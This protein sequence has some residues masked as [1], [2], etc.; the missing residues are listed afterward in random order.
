MKVNREIDYSGTS[1]V[2]PISCIIHSRHPLAFCTIKQV[3]SSDPALRNFVKPYSNIPEQLNKNARSILIIDVC[4]VEH[5]P[6]LLQ[7]WQSKGGYTISLLSIDAQAKGEDLKM[8]Y[9]G[10]DGVVAFTDELVTDLPKAVRTVADGKLW[11]RRETLD[12]YV[13]ET[14]ALL[15]RLTSHAEP[16]TNREQQVMKLLRDGFSNRQIANATGISERTAKFHVSNILRKYQIEDRRKLHASSKSEIVVRS[17]AT[18]EQRRDG[19]QASLRRYPGPASTRTDLAPA[20]GESITSA[21]SS[22][23]A[24]LDR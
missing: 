20:D 7:R 9:L 13:K 19:P 10:V 1:T 5:W 17:N 4:S 21:K 6:E 14:N 16:L 22:Q 24:A 12:R 18:T 15:G 11:V 23:S 2:G 8:L 3:L